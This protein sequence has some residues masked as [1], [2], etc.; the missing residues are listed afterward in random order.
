MTKAQDIR[1]MVDKGITSNK[2]IAK[3]VGANEG[4]IS[5]VKSR[6]I[7]E[8]RLV[9]LGSQNTPPANDPNATPPSPQNNDPPRSSGGAYD[10]GHED[11]Y[12]EGI[13]FINDTRGGDDTTGNKDDDNTGKTGADHH[14]EWI[15]EAKYECNCGCVL[16]RKSKYCP[17]CGMELDW[18][19][20]NG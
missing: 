12:D 13:N 20:F 8:K 18:S 7:K 19:G 3:V 16:N 1:D 9:E 2:E 5:G 10:A 17:R 6:H 11:G 4:Y 15:K 14:K